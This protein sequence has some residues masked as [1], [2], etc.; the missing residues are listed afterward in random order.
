MKNLDRIRKQL[1]PERRQKIKA[2]AAEI[3]AEEDCASLEVWSEYIL[4]A[5]GPNR[6]EKT[7]PLPYKTI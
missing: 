5:L 3:M 7:L 6:A 4:S 1:P 2:R